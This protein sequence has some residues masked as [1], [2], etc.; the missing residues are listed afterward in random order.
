[1]YNKINCPKTNKFYLIETKKGISILKKYVNWLVNN[2]GGGNQ[3]EEEEVQNLK[4]ILEEWRNTESLAPRIITTIDR[5]KVRRDTIVLNRLNRTQQACPHETFLCNIHS[6]FNPIFYHLHMSLKKKILEEKSP[7]KKKLLKILEKNKDHTVHLDLIDINKI[8]LRKDKEYDT[9]IPNEKEYIENIYDIIGTFLE[10]YIEE[11]NP[12]LHFPIGLF[13]YEKARLPENWDKHIPVKHNTPSYILPTPEFWYQTI[14]I[15]NQEEYIIKNYKQ[16]LKARQQNGGGTQ[17]EEEIETPVFPSNPDPRSH[18]YPSRNQPTIR[19]RCT[20]LN[21]YENTHYN[22]RPSKYGTITV[23][24]DDEEKCIRDRRT[25]PEK[26]PRQTEE[27]TRDEKKELNNYFTDFNTQFFFSNRTS[28]IRILYLVL[29][30]M[31]VAI[32]AIN[33]ITNNLFND[34][35]LLFI[36]KGGIITRFIIQD[37]IRDFDSYAENIVNDL[38]KKIIKIGDLDFQLILAANYVDTRW[39]GLLMIINMLVCVLI[40]NYVNN[41]YILFIDFFK[42][43]EDYRNIL[44]ENTIKKIEKDY[45]EPN[46]KNNFY[47]KIRIDAIDYAEEINNSPT[48]SVPNGLRSRPYIYKYREEE[49]DLDPSE[50][51]SNKFETNRDNALK[52]DTIVAIPI[53]YNSNKDEDQS[54][55]TISVEK[56]FDSLDIKNKHTKNK[57]VSLF[58]DDPT[59]GKNRLFF[60]NNVIYHYNN[61]QSILNFSLARLKYNYKIFYRTGPGTQHN[62]LAGERIFKRSSN[63]Q[64]EFIDLSFG[65]KYEKPSLTKYP[66]VNC[67]IFSKY[68]KY[69]MDNQPSMKF[70]SYTIKGLRDDLQQMLFIQH[71][72]EP[73]KDVKY[74]KRLYRILLISILGF[75]YD[76]VHHRNQIDKANILSRFQN[77]IIINSF[78]NGGDWQQY[79]IAYLDNSQ[80]DGVIKKKLIETLRFYEIKNKIQDWDH[81]KLIHDFKTQQQFYN[82][83][84]DE[85][86]NGD[87]D[88]DILLNLNPFHNTLLNPNDLKFQFMGENE[89]DDNFYKSKDNDRNIG[90]RSYSNNYENPSYNEIREG[91]EY[92]KMFMMINPDKY[93]YGLD[94]YIWVLHQPKTDDVQNIVNFNLMYLWDLKNNLKGNK[95]LGNNKVFDKCNEHLNRK[96]KS[97]ADI[98]SLFL[99]IS[100][101]KEAEEDMTEEYEKAFNFILEINE[102]MYT[103]VEQFINA[104]KNNTEFGMNPTYGFSKGSFDIDYPELYITTHKTTNPK[105]P[106][107]LAKDYPTNDHDPRKIY[108]SVGVENSLQKWRRD[109]VRPF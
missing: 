36:F 58:S 109:N 83:I 66:I 4:K 60:T 27:P 20:P 68:C 70:Y 81:D 28:R 86:K 97:E 98:H 38:V 94:N 13:N 76:N 1:M 92:Y 93:N 14:L 72:Y 80:Y 54:L 18:S 79:L 45:N 71:K 87:G 88:G 52:D 102:F 51:I 108:G 73:W 10:T 74:N 15:K 107:V 101:K 77:F 57:F 8:T 96:I 59:R 67:N 37:F 2:R 46:T 90:Y 40:R 11:K 82:I 62:M 95:R 53:P 41:N 21:G 64:G 55:C 6:F 100:R 31:K 29:M 39:Y 50:Y 42:L 56:F 69:T 48:I 103:Y 22:E 19:S 84:I 43:N 32:S 65:L 61:P 33:D 5:T 16:I 75:F 99:E 49:Y 91:G 30:S 7:E 106:E 85:Y 63:V 25:P 104:L 105:L 9:F 12:R 34:Q 26:T 24:L 89:D 17:E 47:H 23:D 35:S 78:F 44:L 3:E